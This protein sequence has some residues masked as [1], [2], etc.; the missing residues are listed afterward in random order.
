MSDLLGIA[1]A[2]LL[3][4]FGLG[5]VT[6]AIYEHVTDGSVTTHE[7]A[8]EIVTGWPVITLVAFIGA[9]AMR[10]AHHDR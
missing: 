10:A 7:E 1:A 2:A 3:I 5:A 9:A 4:Y 8:A 6:L